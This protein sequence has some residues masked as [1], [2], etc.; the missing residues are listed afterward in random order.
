MTNKNHRVLYTGVTSDL[1]RRVYEHKNKLFT[2]SFTSKYQL[3]KLVY[4]EGFHRIEEAIGR[5]KA[6]KGG[7]R[8]GKIKLINSMNPEWKDLYEEVMGW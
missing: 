3:N 5:E 6:I 2:D 4:S 7:S 1:K 8:D